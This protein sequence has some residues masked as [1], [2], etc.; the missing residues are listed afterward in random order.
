MLARPGFCKPLV[1]GSNPAP[2]ISK[3]NKLKRVPNVRDASQKLAG[4]HTGGHEPN[5]ADQ[6]VL[7]RGPSRGPKM[8]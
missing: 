5:Q 8:N 4:G 7:D 3:N 1:A 6:C 2:G